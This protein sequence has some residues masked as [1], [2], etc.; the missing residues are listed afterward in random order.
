MTNL[1]LCGYRKWANQIFD[2][3][4]NHPKVNILKRINSLEE[5]N[6][7]KENFDERI[8]IILFIGWSWIISSEITE[9][10]L[11]LGIHPS[12][13]PNYRGG[14]PIQNQII[15]GLSNTM[16]TL[17]TLSS[18]KLDAGDIWM[19]EHLSLAGDNIDVVF[20]NIKNSTIK[21]LNRFFD[22]YPNL[23]PEE[24]IV[25]KGSYFKRR[26]SEQ[27]RL[28]AED[29]EKMSLNELYNFIRCLTDPYPNAYLEDNLG[30]KLLFTGVKYIPF[31]D[32]GLE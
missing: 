25:S 17:M 23:K 2:E 10:Y 30:N 28:K 11:C 32:S 20:E 4:S 22:F 16:V 24:Q 26:T 1:V 13:L 27:S 7:E 31:N 9:K 12:N 19:K 21:L 14:S 8:D 18:I 5:Y 6:T 29:F 3:I 15:N